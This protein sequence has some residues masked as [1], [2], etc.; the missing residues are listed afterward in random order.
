MAMLGLVTVDEAV[1]VDY[2]QTRIVF[3]NL[4]FVV[5]DDGDS[6]VSR[7]S[8]SSSSL[9]SSS[10]TAGLSPFAGRSPSNIKATLAGRPFAW[11]STSASKPRLMVASICSFVALEFIS[12]F[13]VRQLCQCFFVSHFALGLL[14]LLGAKL[15]CFFCRCSRRRTTT[16]D[17]QNDDDQEISGCRDATTRDR[18]AKIRFK[19]NSFVTPLCLANNN[20]NSLE[21]TT[22]HATRQRRSRTASPLSRSTSNVCSTFLEA[23]RLQPLLDSSRPSVETTAPST[24]ARDCKHYESSKEQVREEMVS[25]HALKAASA[26]VARAAATAVEGGEAQSARRCV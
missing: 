12:K 14:S 21:W 23:A 18:S 13:M 10:E 19:I 9:L 20:N 11:A 25:K 6:K 7:V 2:E 4:A 22:K 15:H 8:S 3:A 26:L 24:E 16:N 1:L 17:R 5:L